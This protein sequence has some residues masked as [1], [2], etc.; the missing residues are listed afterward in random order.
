MAAT[1]M[2]D[3]AKFEMTSQ[4]WQP[5]PGGICGDKLIFLTH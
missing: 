1:D 5:Q 3:N 4:T 2:D